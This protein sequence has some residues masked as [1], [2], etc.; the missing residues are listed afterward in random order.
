M[1]S[2]EIPIAVLYMK[3]S[4]TNES[5]SLGMQFRGCEPETKL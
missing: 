4:V 2:I 1:T 5:A 3:W